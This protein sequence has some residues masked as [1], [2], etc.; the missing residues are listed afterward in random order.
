M[1]SLGYPAEER[2]AYTEK[3]MDMTKVHFNKW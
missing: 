2:S 3:D 1:I